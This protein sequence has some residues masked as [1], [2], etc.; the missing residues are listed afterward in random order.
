MIVSKEMME[1]MEKDIIIDIAKQ[2][3]E[4]KLHR[5]SIL[6]EVFLD[7]IK[8]NVYRQKSMTLDEI[9]K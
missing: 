4:E 3:A 1:T 7:C 6:D 9:L 2:Q 8:T 5:F